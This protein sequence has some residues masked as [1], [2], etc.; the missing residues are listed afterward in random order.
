MSVMATLDWKYVEVVPGR[1][2]PPGKAISEPA[3]LARTL[4]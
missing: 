4:S 2:A 3:P 1:A